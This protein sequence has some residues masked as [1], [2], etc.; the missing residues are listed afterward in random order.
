MRDH[1]TAVVLGIAAAVGVL[2]TSAGC[3]LYQGGTYAYFTD[4]AS[5]AIKI[6]AQQHEPSLAEERSG[7]DSGPEDGHV[8]GDPGQH[9]TSPGREAGD[10]ATPKPPHREPPTTDVSPSAGAG[11]QHSVDNH[12][13]V[14]RGTRPDAGSQSA[15]PP[16]GPKPSG[17][18]PDPKPPEPA[19]G[20]SGH[21]LS[22]HPV[23]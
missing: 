15:K 8:P 19:T 5:V 18:K 4:S 16:A 12:A 6:A 21:V 11:S 20:R 9:A 2:G 7:H 23:R 22:R 3:L 14:N 10:H 13:N 17:P 1:R